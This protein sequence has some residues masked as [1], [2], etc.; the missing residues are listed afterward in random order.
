MRVVICRNC[1]YLKGDY[2]NS[3]KCPVC[4]HALEDS[5]LDFNTFGNMSKEEEDNFRLSLQN[6][7]MYD[8]FYWNKRIEK[9]KYLH[10]TIQQESAQFRT[11]HPEC[12]YCHNRNTKK[13][14]NSIQSTKHGDV[15]VI[16]Y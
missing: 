12:P 15:W 7:N 14:N 3:I 9:D 8:P 4:N 2:Q 6:R 13:N 11:S 10:E 1:G 16:R 5:G